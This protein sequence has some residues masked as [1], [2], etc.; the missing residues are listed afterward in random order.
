MRQRQQ[1]FHLLEII[2]TTNDVINKVE[3]I[4]RE[5]GMDFNGRKEL[6][7]SERLSNDSRQRDENEAELV[8]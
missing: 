2:K 6:D 8:R 7:I 1:S 5:L 4:S 3:P